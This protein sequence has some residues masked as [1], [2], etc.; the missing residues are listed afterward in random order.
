MIAV[1]CT[2]Y[3]GYTAAVAVISETL[4]PWLNSQGRE[5]LWH[6]SGSTSRPK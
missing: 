6:T 3:G 1:H 2:S 4:R 5:I